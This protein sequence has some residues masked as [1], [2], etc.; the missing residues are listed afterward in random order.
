MFR[1]N[2]LQLFGDYMSTVAS[3]FQTLD[4]LLELVCVDLQ[5]SE[6]QDFLARSHY[7]AVTDWLACDGSPLEMLNP[8][9][10][11]Q[12]S[13]RLGTTTRPLRHSEYDLDA[14]C[15]LTVVGDWSPGELY[16]LIWNRLFESGVY[17]PMIK[18]MPRC[19]RLE[20]SGSFH[21]DIAPAIQDRRCGGNCI[22]VPDLDANLSIDHPE[23]NRWKSTN[24][25]D[26]ADWFE[27]QCVPVWTLNSKYARAQVDPVP[28]QESVHAKPALKRSVQL[29]KRWR[30]VAYADRP[31]LAPPS[32]IVTTLGGM[33]YEGQ[34]LCTD[35][36]QSILAATVDQIE[37]GV[38]LRLTN[39]AHPAENI[40]EKWDDNPKAYDDFSESITELR[41]R[42][43]RLATLRGIPAIERE[44]SELF[45]ESP[46]R[47]A[48]RAMTDR[49]VVHP[50]SNSRLHVQPRSGMLIPA[51]V[52]GAGLRIP[53]TTF[54]GDDK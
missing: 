14:V 28:E 9:I 36:V 15:K 43:E 19:I 6:T 37:S 24:P 51:S 50:R 1:Y 53:S 48:V 23:N 34:Q 42:W 4:A 41:D 5:L 8:H 52:I 44:L 25:Q 45:G 18:R 11:P 39:P 46:V 26:Y 7:R 29:L 38:P 27:G 31:K 13:Q 12:G 32:I 47:S 20:Y 17:R 33:L 35:S 3:G 40:C 2:L 54:H 49:T 30:D 21:L 16:Q 10:F 22:L